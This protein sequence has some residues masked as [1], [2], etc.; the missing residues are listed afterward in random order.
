MLSPVRSYTFLCPPGTPGF[1]LESV[2]GGERLARYSFI[3]FEPKSLELSGDA[4]LAA[5]G[6]VAAELTAPVRGVPRFHGGAVGYLGYETA[7]HFER[8]PLAEGAPP[9]M[10]ESAFL[11]AEDLAV[12]DHVTRRLKLLT[13]FRPG[14]EDYE[15]AVAR[16]DTMEERL[17]SDQ[18]AVWPRGVDG[19]P[20]KSNVTPGQFHA[21][22]DAAPREHLGG[23]PGLFGVL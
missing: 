11:R 1:L 23:G 8:L 2:E 3:G 4:P 5:P 6:K 10:P 13:I 18:V 7:R 15:S 22:V 9:P 20:W 14:N 12:F 19:T 21:M 16:I 17:S